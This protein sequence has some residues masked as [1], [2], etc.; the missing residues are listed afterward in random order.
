M[1]GV[2]ILHGNKCMKLT[3]CL[4]RVGASW[5][6][7][8][9]P[10]HCY[11]LQLQHTAV[12]MAVHPAYHNQHVSSCPICCAEAGCDF[13]Q[14]NCD[15]YMKRTPGQTYFCKD[16]NG[17][18]ECTFD[19]MAVGVCAA[20][21]YTNGCNLVQAYNDAS[22]CLDPGQQQVGPWP[23]NSNSAYLF[24]SCSTEKE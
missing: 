3:C 4:I 22:N 13:S 12:C 24:G 7:R 2:M 19:R 6:G 23:Q 9:A 5:Y 11:R 21:N 10:V 15:T 14:E 18:D 20:S 17:K 1:N 8:I 16:L